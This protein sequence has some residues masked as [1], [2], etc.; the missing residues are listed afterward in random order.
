MANQSI[1]TSKWFAEKK[2]L[3]CDC[4]QLDVV[5][6]TV[7]SS[8]LRRARQVTMATN[9]EKMRQ[10]RRANID[11]KFMAIKW[12]LFYWS[13]ATRS[14]KNSNGKIIQCVAQWFVW[15]FVNIWCIQN[16]QIGCEFYDSFYFCRTWLFFLLQLITD[17]KNIVFWFSWQKEITTKNCEYIHISLF[18]LGRQAYI[19]TNSLNSNWRFI[20]MVF[21]VR[22]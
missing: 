20:E 6:L 7:Q 2:I 13:I 16:V 4:S 22:I 15:H 19:H 14:N 10:R 9:I 18:I 5:Q 1:T 3:F 11:D 17:H 8:C 21:F 12:I